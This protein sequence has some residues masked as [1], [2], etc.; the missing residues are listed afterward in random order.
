MKNDKFMVVSPEIGLIA[1]LSHIV[2]DMYIIN[3]IM[4]MP[5]NN[6]KYRYHD[7]DFNVG[8]VVFV[9]DDG[10]KLFRYGLASENNVFDDI[11]STMLYSELHK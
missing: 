2:D 11:E 6:I 7:S 9:N 1:R 3:E 4:N 5:E 10:T 8:D